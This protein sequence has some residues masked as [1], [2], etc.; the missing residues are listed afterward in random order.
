MRSVFKTSALLGLLGLSGLFLGATCSPQESAS[1]SVQISGSGTVSANPPGGVYES[2]TQVT[3]TAAPAA[4]WSFDRWTGDLGGSSNPATL[5]MDGDKYVTAVFRSGSGSTGQ[6]VIG[7]VST[8]DGV[9]I[10]AVAV[11]L[12]N[13]SSM[14]TDGYGYFSFAVDSGEGSTIVAHFSKGGFAPMSK[15][16]TVQDAATARP[17]PIHMAPADVTVTIDSSKESKT[18]TAQSAVTIP[19]GSLRNA[20]GQPVTGDVEL[21]V[22]HLDPSTDAVLAFPGS[23]GAATDAGGRQVALESF[24]FASY[25]LTQSGQPVNLAPGQTATIEYVLPANAQAGYRV[26]DK[27]GLWEFKRETATWIEAGQGEVRLASDGSGQLAWFAQVPHFSDWNCDQSQERH[28]ITGRVVMDAPDPLAPLTDES[29]PLAPLTD[30]P[31]PLAPLVSGMT[32]VAGATVIATGISYNGTDTA[33]T[34]ANGNFCVYAKSGSTCSVEIRLNG[35][36]APT[37]YQVSGS[38]QSFAK[39]IVYVPEGKADCGGDCVNMGEIQ[40]PLNSAVKG[41]ITNNSGQPANGVKVHLSSGTSAITDANGEFC[42]KAPAGMQVYVYAEGWSATMATTP[43]SATC[44]DGK[45]AEVTLDIPLATDNDTLG[46]LTASSLVSYYESQ[47]S[48]LTMPMFG[49]SG[50]FMLRNGDGG[51]SFSIPGTTVIY[52]QDDPCSITVYNTFYTYR[53][54]Q[55]VFAQA[56]GAHALDPGNPGTADNG[57]TPVLLYRDD[58]VNPD[59]PWSSGYFSPADGVN[60]LSLGFQAGQTINF[61]FP[62]GADIGEFDASITMPA[63]L[64]VKSPSL[65]DPNATISLT[66][67]LRLTWVAGRSTDTVQVVI[68][69]GTAAVDDNLD[70]STT[71][72][73]RS[74]AVTCDFPDT[75][76]ATVPVERLSRIPADTQNVTLLVFRTR[77]TQVD[78]PLKSTGGTGKIEVTG[79]TGITRAFTLPTPGNGN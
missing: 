25:E 56:P 78:V 51:M 52:E 58:A 47:G 66:A 57:I 61:H 62:G 31:D 5:T 42:A 40:I 76:A 60:P 55:S 69:G 36:P 10:P 43:D 17:V 30:E 13:G 45:A 72:A 50:I 67:D 79:E 49:L 37:L 18:R 27:I 9:P 23:F 74:V 41:R 32:P 15:S 21:S 63:Q 20:S 70:G 71:V 26:G 75:G 39:N 16:M 1:L 38:T 48:M 7:Q 65:S 46:T 28:C 54:G 77:T 2:G 64:V 22:T 59:T 6:A 53:D 35:S 14:S 4:G 34:D 8:V 19:A 11:T 24:G 29:D 44:D 33:I 12:A 73:G 3:L 68:T